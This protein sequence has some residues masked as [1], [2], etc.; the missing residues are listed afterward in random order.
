MGNISKIIGVIFAL[1]LA[2]MSIFILPHKA[3]AIPTKW[4]KIDVSMAELLNSGWKISGHSSSRTAFNN[5]TIDRFDEITYTFL[6][7]KNNDYIFCNTV[8]PSQP[9]ANLAACRKIN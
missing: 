2:V 3:N 4:E 8:N 6:L 9:K 5:G 7:T 1:S